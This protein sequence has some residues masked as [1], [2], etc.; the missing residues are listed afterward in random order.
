MVAR[1]VYDH[2]MKIFKEMKVENKARAAKVYAVEELSLKIYKAKNDVQSE[3]D[4][5]A[6]EF[7]SL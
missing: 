6:S 7:Q 5:F 1:E 4:D 2:E 3:L